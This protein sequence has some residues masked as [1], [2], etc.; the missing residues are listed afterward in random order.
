MSVLV[1]VLIGHWDLGLWRYSSNILLLST[2]KNQLQNFGNAII[3][4]HVQLLRPS[5]FGIPYHGLDKTC[6]HDGLLWYV[7][8]IGH[9]SL[10]W[11]MY[12]VSES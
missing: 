6:P 1:T 8:C 10:V 9:Y 5:V 7:T 11:E 12:K 4:E 2:P 3:C